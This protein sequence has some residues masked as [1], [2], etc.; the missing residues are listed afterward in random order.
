MSSNWIFIIILMLISLFYFLQ[1]N[2]FK[3]GVIFFVI[4]LITGG[5]TGLISIYFSDYAKWILSCILIV[6]AFILNYPPS[7]KFV[8]DN[9][10]NIFNKK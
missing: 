7:K 9:I 5:I 10:K 4:T 2:G 6:I 8:F 3:K 1:I